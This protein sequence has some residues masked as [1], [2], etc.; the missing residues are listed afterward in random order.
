[1]AQVLFISLYDRN[2]YGQRLMCAN[3]KRHGHM[4][5]MVFL[6]RYDTKP[7][8]TIMEVAEDEYPWMGVNRRGRVFKFAANSRISD[9]ELA[10][11]RGLV[12]E[13]EPQMI[14][15]TVNTPLRSQAKRVT[16]FLRQHFDIPVLWGGYDPT[17]NP[18]ACLAHADFVCIGEGDKTILEIARHLDEGL[19]LD[20]IPG[21]AYTRNGAAVVNPK[22]PAEQDLDSFPWRDNEARD[23]YFIEEDRLERH[24]PALNDRE[25]GVYLTMTSRGCPYKCTYCCEATLK[26]VYSGEKFLRR[27]SVDDVIAELVTAKRRF[28]IE[29]VYFDDEIFAMDV[30]W[31]ERFSERY[32]AEVG[33][34]FVAYIYPTR[35]IGRILELL[36]AAGLY[37]CCLALESGSERVNKVVFERV[38]DRALFLQTAALLEQHGI[39]F[40]TDVITY[41]PYETEEDLQKTLDVLVDLSHLMARG[42]DIWVNKLFVLPGTKLARKMA[43]DGVVIGPSD[44]DPVFNYYTRL[45]WIASFCGGSRPLIERI[46]ELAVFKSAPW[47]LD[48]GRVEEWLLT[49]APIHAPLAVAADFMAEEPGARKRA[50]AEFFEDHDAVELPALTLA[51]CH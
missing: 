18:E 21:L 33:L 29:N 16:E 4:C 42:Y 12:A 13:L 50:Q 6:K 47:L 37:Y 1:M 11:L 25:L 14:G 17:V 40:Y 51:G 38:Y 23:K 31:L 10:L 7:T 27:R 41:S 19:S 9:H 24:H 36:K 5:D 34:P 20:K 2:A 30:K 46:Q 32:Q 43:A 44:M 3:L 26:D 49:H 39:R 22:F 8:T 48:T 35:N 28:A 45:C 15:L